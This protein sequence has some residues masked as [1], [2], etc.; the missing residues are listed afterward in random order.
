MSATTSSDPDPRPD[1][2]RRRLSIDTKLAN[3]LT[4]PPLGSASST[5]TVSPTAAGPDTKLELQF[6][7]L[8]PVLSSHLARQKMSMVGRGVIEFI[9]PAERERQSPTMIRSRGNAS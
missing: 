1:A 5:S 3:T 8:D 2:K 7:H 6:L 4:V 9:H